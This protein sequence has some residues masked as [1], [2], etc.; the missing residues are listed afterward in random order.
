MFAIQ[1][2]MVALF[3]SCLETLDGCANDQEQANAVEVFHLPYFAIYSLNKQDKP[4]EEKLAKL[5]FLFKGNDF[6]VP[7]LYIRPCKERYI[8]S[9]SYKGMFIHFRRGCNHRGKLQKFYHP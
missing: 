6:S 4:F 8:N 9:L 3:F 5:G 2:A 1:V 7:G